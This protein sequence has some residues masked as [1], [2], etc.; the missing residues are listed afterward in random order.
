MSESHAFSTRALTL[1]QRLCLGWEFSLLWAQT[2]I[3]GLG[4]ALS[5]LQYRGEFLR[6]AAW[7]SHLDFYCLVIVFSLLSFS[8]AKGA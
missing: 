4:S 2:L 7:L 6:E 1:A 8:R 3:L 5:G